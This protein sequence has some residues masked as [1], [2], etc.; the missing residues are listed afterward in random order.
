MRQRISLAADS[1]EPY[2][3]LIKPPATHHTPVTLEWSDLE[4]WEEAYPKEVEKHNPRFLELVDSIIEADPQAV[5]L[6]LGDH[7]AWRYRG[8]ANHDVRTDLSIVLQREGINEHIL[9]LDLF[10]VFQGIRHPGG[11]PAQ[12]ATPS[13]V[14]LFRRL[15]AALADDA[16]IADLPDETFFQRRGDLYVVVR[17]G[18]PLE[19]WELATI[20]GE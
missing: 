1:P 12:L 8:L 4:Y 6:M 5:I 11:D 20:D 7:G 3:T 18:R 10:G 17:D 14:N 9:A 19:R 15:F 2:F 16:G 13:N